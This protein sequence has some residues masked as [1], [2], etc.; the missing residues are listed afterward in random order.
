MLLIFVITFVICY[1]HLL[2]L[3]V[4]GNLLRHLDVVI[5]VVIGI[6]FVIGIGIAGL[7]AAEGMAAAA[8]RRRNLNLEVEEDGAALKHRTHFVQTIETTMIK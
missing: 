5:V 3:Y 7:I 2:P 8:G 1:C 6:P 4:I